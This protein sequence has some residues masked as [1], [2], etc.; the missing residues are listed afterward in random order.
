MAAIFYYIDVGK[1]V[2]SL[3]YNHCFFS[4]TF[5]IH[6]FFLY[7]LKHS[8]IAMLTSTLRSLSQRGPVVARSFSSTSAAHAAEVKSL[9]VIG[10]GQ[11]V[12]KML[13]RARLAA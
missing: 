9:G 3:Q 5:H 6:I 12:S 7:S 2:K 13:F 8:N 10:A 11:M 1:H 4:L